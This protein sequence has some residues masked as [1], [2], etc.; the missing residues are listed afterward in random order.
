MHSNRNCGVHDYSICADEQTQQL[1]Y[2]LG[3]VAL[4]DKANL[5]AT[6]IP[7]MMEMFQRPV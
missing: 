3:A 6:L 1:A 2:A 4:L 7:T 5:G